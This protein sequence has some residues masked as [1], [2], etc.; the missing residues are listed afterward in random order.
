MQES[1]FTEAQ[2]TAVLHGWAAGANMTERL[3]HHGVTEQT[4]YR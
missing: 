4:R 1:R 2:I 3:R